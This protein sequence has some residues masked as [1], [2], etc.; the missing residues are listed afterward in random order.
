MKKK[1]TMVAAATV[2]AMTLAAC[3]DPTAGPTGGDAD[4]AG[5]TWP[6]ATADLTGTELT[7]WAAQASAS[8]PTAVIEAFEA[9]TG[10]VVE[11]ITVPDPYEQGIQ[12]RVATGDM[13]DL[14]FWQ[15]TPS[16]LTAINAPTNLQPLDGAPWLEN[17]DPAV[18]DVTGILDGTRYAALISSPT[19]QGVFY[20]RAVFAEHGI[21]VPSDW[22]ELVEAAQTLHG[23]GQTPFFDFL[24]PAGWATQWAVQ[25]QLADA[26]ADGL[27]ERINA[28]EEAFTDETVLT[29]IQNYKDMIDGGLFNANIASATFEDQ[30]TA[31][32]SG[33]A[34]M[35]FQI[36]AL[37]GAMQV[38]ASAAEVDEAVGFFPI[39]PSGNVATVS[40]D[41]T[42]G[43]VAFRTGDAD[44]EAAA[45]QF[46]SFWLGE[47]YETFIQDQ[48]TVSLLSTVE[49]PDSVPQVTRDL[50]AAVANSVGSMQ[51]EAIVNP[52]LFLFLANMAQGTLTPE[53]AAQNTQDHFVQLARALGADGF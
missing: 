47:G 30:A 26:A 15:P 9:A 25:V 51:A 50:A 5:A 42:N 41:Q 27:W 18:R 8:I 14:A 44:R 36:N 37:V 28:G 31:L 2:V 12:T 17:M 38:Q 22:D 48:A 53:Q 46:L 32:L 29:A 45:R 3:S 24:S 23:A 49:T 7:L 13:P 40:P 20:N 11:V 16:M 4:G 33:D 35:A 21:E 52:D 39:S 6:E 1:L 19:V 10:A 43:V 34:A